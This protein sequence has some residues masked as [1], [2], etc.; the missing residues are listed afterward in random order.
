MRRF[1][2]KALL[3]C[4][5]VA[6]VAFGAVAAART[7]SS[8]TKVVLDQFTETGSGP[9]APGHLVGHLEAP[10]QE[11]G[12]G[13]T[14]R[15]FM[16]NGNDRTITLADT[17]KTGRHGGWVLDGGLFTIDRAQVRATRK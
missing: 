1:G 6:C 15:L 11:G 9:D 17:D 10:Q 3:L 13:R 5:A 8:P 16:R 4:T 2:F 12:R 14:V 7:A